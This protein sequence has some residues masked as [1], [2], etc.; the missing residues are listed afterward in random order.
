MSA[1]SQFIA[2][3]CLPAATLVV[4]I[5]IIIIIIII[6]MIIIQSPLLLPLL[7]HGQPHQCVS[8]PALSKYSNAAGESCHLIHAC[9]RQLECDCSV[10]DLVIRPGCSTNSFEACFS[11]WVTLLLR[12]SSSSACVSFF[13][14]DFLHLHSNVLGFTNCRTTRKGSFK[15]DTKVSFRFKYRSGHP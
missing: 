1:R 10:A 14:S 15:V 2:S 11:F 3:M 8:T 6:I 9:R 13:Y 5:Q 12:F 7:R 4:R